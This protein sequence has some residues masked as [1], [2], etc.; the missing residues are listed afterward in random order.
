MFDKDTS[1]KIYI[2]YH[3]SWTEKCGSEELIFGELPDSTGAPLKG[4][5]A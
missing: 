4:V 2:P 3:C 5:V 1:N